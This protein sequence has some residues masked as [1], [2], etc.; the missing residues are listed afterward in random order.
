MEL[1]YPYLY[2]PKVS[3]NIAVCSILQQREGLSAE[4]VFRKRNIFLVT[5]HYKVELTK[6]QQLTVPGFGSD[7]IKQ[8]ATQSQKSLHL[9]FTSQA[10][11]AMGKLVLRK[12]GKQ[13][14]LWT[15]DH[16]Q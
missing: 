12:E 3:Q 14:C 2:L 1:L 6:H 8:H 5:V 9:T 15:Q 7:C 10:L 11:H 16:D 4:N 13:K